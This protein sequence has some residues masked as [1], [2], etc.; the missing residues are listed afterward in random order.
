MD[1]QT[2]ELLWRRKILLVAITEQ[3]LMAELFTPMGLA[4]PFEENAK[5]M[6]GRLR[7]VQDKLEEIG[8]E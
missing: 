5:R 1:K 2:A 7:K 6:R 4:M 8:Y 3:K